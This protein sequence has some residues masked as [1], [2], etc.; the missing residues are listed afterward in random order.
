MFAVD[1]VRELA[2]K[3]AK[4]QHP[5]FVRTRSAA[6]FSQLKA[7][8]RAAHASTHQAKDVTALA[9][10]E[11][12]QAHLGLQNLLYER[13]HLEREIEKCRQFAWVYILCFSKYTLF[14]CV[15]SVHPRES[16]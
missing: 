4:D 16:T 13:R 10:Q 11:M 9:R 7:A 1:C 6:L 12:D 3:P 8:N 5:D 14:T 15:H 2:T